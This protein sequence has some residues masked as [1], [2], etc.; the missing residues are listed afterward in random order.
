MVFSS[1]QIK[2]EVNL[3]VNVS[4]NI[5]T[6][7]LGFLWWRVVVCGGASSLA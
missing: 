7:G 6:V 3:R 4:S 5:G 1:S 2:N